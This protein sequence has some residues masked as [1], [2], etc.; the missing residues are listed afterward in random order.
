MDVAEKERGVGVTVSMKATRALLVSLLVLHALA[1][2]TKAVRAMRLENKSPPQ[3]TS[4]DDNKWI[5]IPLAKASRADERRRMQQLHAGIRGTHA[6]ALSSDDF[7]DVR[8]AH[9]QQRVRRRLQDARADGSDDDDDDDDDDEG[10]VD[11]GGK[12]TIANAT[13]PKPMVYSEVP[14]GV[15]FGCVCIILLVKC[16]PYADDGG[17]LMRVYI[18]MIIGRTMLSSTWGSQ[19]NARP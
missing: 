5:R 18:C 2:D 19:R 16:L 1:T 8:L 4:N 3:Q 13:A 7:R 9:Q 12:I 15:G 11:D 10:G 6:V 17:I 14:L